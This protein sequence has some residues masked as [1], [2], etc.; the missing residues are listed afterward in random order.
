MSRPS[1]FLIFY[2]CV[3]QEQYVGEALGG[4]PKFELDDASARGLIEF[5]SGAA[6]DGRP[7]MGAFH[8]PSFIRPRPAQPRDIG[9]S[10]S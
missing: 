4:L 7:Y 2:P 6:R 9:W 5:E 3:W 10:P 1:F 8:V